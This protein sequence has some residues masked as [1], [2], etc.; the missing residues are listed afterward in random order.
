MPKKSRG[1][2]GMG[3]VRQR[4][5][6]S[7]EARYTA[8]DGRQKSL[9]ARTEKDVTAKLRATLREIDTGHWKEPS[10]M[11]VGEWLDIWLRDYQGHT[12]GRTLETYTGIVNRT[13]KPIF[14]KV[15]LSSFGQ[16][17]VRRMVNAMIADGKAPSTIKHARGILSASMKCAIEAGIIKENPVQGVKGPR[18]V[19]P[20]FTIV[21]REQFGAFVEAARKTKYGNELIFLL[22]TGLRVGE[23]R[24]LKWEDIDGSELHIVRQLHAP[25]HNQRFGQPKDGEARVVQITPE[26]VEVLKEQRKKQLEQR[27]SAGANWKEDDISRGLVFRTA[28]GA[29]HSENS[30]YLAVRQVANELN[31]PDL[32]PHDL[33]HSYAVA[34]LR[35]GI[36][37]KT[38]QHNLGHKHA[39]I[40]LDTY[41]AYTTDAGKIGAEKLSEYWKNALK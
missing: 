3:S 15:K 26:A 14:G 25:T 24:G 7:W 9:Y 19:K 20:R 11:T 29:T 27:I 13:F 21:D 36:D 33:R 12:T 1:A 2:N 38:V 10:K 5:D 17:H 37:V 31:M 23:L 4:A 34:A 6:G 40:T 18:P 32:H 35:S 22:L 39:S 28:R 41:A 16:I 8:P 30:I